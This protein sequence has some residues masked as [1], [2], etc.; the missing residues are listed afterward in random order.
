MSYNVSKEQAITNAGILY[1]EGACDSIKLEG[2]QEMAKTIEAI[3]R[4]GIP[5]F[6]HIG[7]TPQTAGML[8]GFKVQGK[9]LDAAKK[10]IDDAIAVDEAGA[11]AIV[12]ES[13][14]R[15]LAKIISQKVKAITIGIGAGMECDGQVLVFHDILG[16]FKRF[17]PK[18]VKVYANAWDYE[19]KAVK[20]FIDEVKE[21]K[22]PS[23]EFTYTM[24]EDVLNEL[25]KYA[26]I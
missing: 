1:K 7:L 4:A 5:T 15:Q 2:G 20:D 19:L 6:G 16:L 14:P 25:K 13:I 11:F 10:L 23:D 22:F 24:K 21:Q 12:L 18:F 8:G 3:V 26:E 17:T 9:S